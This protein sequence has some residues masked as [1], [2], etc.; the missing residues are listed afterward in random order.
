MSTVTE[1]V[2]TQAG[3]A[4]TPW[5]VP[6]WDGLRERVLR[7]QH[8]TNCQRNV[9]PARKFCPYCAA[10]AF[11][12]RDSAGRGSI[13]SF[14]VLEQGAIAAFADS[15]PYAIVI[16]QLNEGVRVT[17]RIERAHFDDLACDLPVR[18][19]FDDLH[20]GL[21]SFMLSGPE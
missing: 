4:R 3:G 20:E 8:C 1:P 17:S 11:E 14:S 19:D 15:A 7:Y 2:E 21:P 5:S 10:A 12:W 9:F 18:V 13:Y 6:Y 16:V